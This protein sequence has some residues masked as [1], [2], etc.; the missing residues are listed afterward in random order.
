MRGLGA[1]AVVIAHTLNWVGFFVSLT[2]AETHV[3]DALQN[4]GWMGVAMFL[5]LSIY[6][7]MGSLDAN[8]DL[9]RYFLR[10]MRRIWPLY[11]AMCLILFWLAGWNWSELAWNASFLAT[12]SPTHLFSF[13]RWPFNTAVWTL[14][15]EELAYLCFPLIAALNH[16]NRVRAGWGLIVAAGLSVLWLGHF[17]HVGG[18]LY[19]MPWPWLACYGFG[20]LAY[21]KALP[22]PSWMKWSLLLVLVPFLFPDPLEWPE[23]MFYLGPTIAWVIAF[24]PAFL[25]RFV[26]V[27]VGECSYALYLIHQQFIEFFGPAG[28]PLAYVSAWYV[29]SVQRRKQMRER[30]AMTVTSRAQDPDRTAARE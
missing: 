24:P 11:F 7:L 8:R 17:E 12:L 1:S 6:L 3:N 9:T 15:V 4:L 14:Q 20:L 29:E 19:Y 2:Y 27:A 16:A 23:A 28:V 30:L 21:E 18:L 22:F 10:R 26:L 25:R 13:S 5:T